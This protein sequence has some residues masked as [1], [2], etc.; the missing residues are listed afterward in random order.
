MKNYL[1]L[2]PVSIKVSNKYQAA[3]G[4]PMVR[5]GGLSILTR[6]SGGGMN[7]MGYHPRSSLTWLWFIN[8]Y[9]GKAM[10]PQKWGSHGH[11]DFS[12]PFGWVLRYHWQ[13]RMNRR[14]G[15]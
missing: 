2:G 5:I 13:K 15:Q 7:L 10:A 14:V 12:L 6:D 3:W 11:R 1:R 8:A 9:R 4:Y